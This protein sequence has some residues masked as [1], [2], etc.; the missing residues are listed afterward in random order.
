MPYTI[1]ISP[2]STLVSGKGK[3]MAVTFLSIGVQ[4]GG[5]SVGPGIQGFTTR[6]PIPLLINGFW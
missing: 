5:G 3:G 4:T 6:W 2:F 1:S